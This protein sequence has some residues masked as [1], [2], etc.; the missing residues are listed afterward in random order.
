M[1]LRSVA[2]SLALLLAPCLMFSALSGPAAA[3][4]CLHCPKTTFCRPLEPRIR[5]KS[6]CP[7][8]ICDPCSMENYG[9]YPTC[10]HPWPFPPNYGHC[11]VPPTTMTAPPCC[12]PN[13]IGAAAPTPLNVPPGVLAARPGL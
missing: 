10:W 5:Y 11:E 13:C 8:P 2:S 4:E 9:Y 1:T 3:A 7:K 12:G 6:V